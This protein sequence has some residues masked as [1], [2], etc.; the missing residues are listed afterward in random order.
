MSNKLLQNMKNKI[1]SFLERDGLYYDDLP[2][3]EE[4]IE[5]FLVSFVSFEISIFIEEN[6]EFI[7]FRAYRTSSAKLDKNNEILADLMKRNGRY[8]M[9]KWGVD[10]RGDI[11]LYLDFPSNNSDISYE[12]FDRMFSAIYSEMEDTEKLFSQ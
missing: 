3:E 2:L 10:S 6:G 9:I 8:Q 11:G 1:S 5:G 7:H 4:D 12:Q